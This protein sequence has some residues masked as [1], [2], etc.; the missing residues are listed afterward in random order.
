MPL[1]TSDLSSLL[2]ALVAASPSRRFTASL[3]TACCLLKLHALCSMPY[4]GQLLKSTER[5]CPTTS[6]FLPLDGGG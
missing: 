1:L 4:H 6:K 2:S 5:G 3:R